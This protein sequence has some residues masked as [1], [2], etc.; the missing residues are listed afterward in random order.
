[1]SRAPGASGA[2]PV[3]PFPA[4]GMPVAEEIDGARQHP[5]RPRDSAAAA[6]NADETRKR[7]AGARVCR[8]C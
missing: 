7:F 1:M 4:G 3:E 2:D 5:A 6:H 8:A